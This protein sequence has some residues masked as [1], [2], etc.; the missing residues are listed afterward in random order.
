MFDFAF[1]H[2]SLMRELLPSDFSKQPQLIDENFKAGVLASAQAQAS[3]G[4]DNLAFQISLLKGKPIYQVDSIAQNLVLRKF[5]RNIKR[6]TRVKQSD[7]NTIIKSLKSLFEEGH[8]FRVYKLD[9]RNFYESIDR[10]YIENLLKKDH[11]LPPT[12]LRVYKS[13]NGELLAQNISGL[14]RGLAISATLS[15]YVMRQFDKNIKSDAH[16]YFYARYVDDIVIISTGQESKKNFLKKIIRI[17]PDGLEL[18]YNKTRIRDFDRPK[19]NNANT[20][21]LEDTVDFL[22]YRFSIFGQLRVADRIT[23]RVLVDLSEN[24]TTRFKTRLILSA[25]QFRK[26]NNFDDLHDRLRILSGNYNVYDLGRKI[27]RNVGIYYNYRFVDFEHSVHLRELD[28]FLKALILSSTGKV[29]T[30]FSALSQ[31]QR[32]ILLGLSFQ[33]SFKT[34]A[35]HHF[36]ISRLSY[37]VRCWKYE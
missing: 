27:R 25:L 35:F 36:K 24:K 19:V 11:G 10:V 37:L 28:A 13:L 8:N 18:N 34:A 26:D 1:D 22:G 5:S 29:G 33:R 31:T 20:Q 6:L 21:T 14:P 17:L 7:R 2:R 32:K 16:V 23:R 3:S 30:A 15:E 9:I 12:T 4:F